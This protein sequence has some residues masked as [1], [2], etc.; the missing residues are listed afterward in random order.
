MGKRMDGWILIFQ[1]I[2]DAYFA[3]KG[4]NL[5]FR[6]WLDEATREIEKK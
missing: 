3:S 4:W 1:V 2:F 6:R 5:S